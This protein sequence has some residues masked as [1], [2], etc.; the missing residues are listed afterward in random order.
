MLNNVYQD[1]YLIIYT[2]IITINFI[3]FYK[4]RYLVGMIIFYTIYVLGEVWAQFQ[5]ALVL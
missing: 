5:C 4:C 1:L 3:S 2:I